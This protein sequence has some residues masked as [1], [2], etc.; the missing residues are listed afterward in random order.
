[1]QRRT[2]AKWWK[3]PLI[4]L[5]S[6]SVSLTASA[7]D[8]DLVALSTGKAMLVID[9]KKPKMFPVGS[10]II[11]NTKLLSIDSA[12][13]TLETDGKK[14]II[15]LGRPGPSSDGSSRITSITMSADNTG[16]FYTQGK[17]NGGNP[18][19]MIIDTGASLVS[20]PAFE[21]QRMGIDYRR[22]K[23]ISSETANGVI[24]SYFIVLNSVK[25]GAV[26]LFHV[27]A[28]VHENLPV[29]LLGMSFL[30]R[31]SMNVD[32]SQMVITKKP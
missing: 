13:A 32:G 29:I 21:A 4:T 7:T 10:A 27:E 2:T 23:K 14:Q 31:V 28:N 20:I 3:L 1:M 25:I 16:H 22:G 30:K 11:G 19:K 26:E 17:I 18:V 9:G 5:L 6:F 12:S 24:T 15:I 8:I